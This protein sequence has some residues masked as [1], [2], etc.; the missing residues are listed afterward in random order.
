MQQA[1]LHQAPGCLE[2][3]HM[4]QPSGKR[5]CNAA[6]GDMLAAVVMEGKG[7]GEV[8]VGV[9]VVVL[10]LTFLASSLRSR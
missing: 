6:A 5:C 10:T 3:G 2:R 9:M 8:K 1:G 4:R 7:E